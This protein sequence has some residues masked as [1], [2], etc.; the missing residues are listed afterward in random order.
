MNQTMTIFYQGMPCYDILLQQGFHGLYEA[1]AAL[2]ME[3]RRICIVTDSNVNAYYGE[4]LEHNLKEHGCTQILRFVFP[5]GEEHKTLAVIE[6]L[7]EF[8]IQHEFDRSDVLLALGGG[9]VGDM[10]GFAAA[11]YLRGIRFVQVPTTLLSMVD[12]SIG[13]KT[14]V[15]FNGYKN[16][17]GAFYQPSLVFV[18]TNVLATLDERQR[19]SGMGEIIKHGLIKDRSYYEWLVS[20]A[21]E[22]L[23]LDTAALA[24]MIYRSQQ[25]KKAVVENDPKE[26]GERALLNFGHTIGHAIEKALHFKLLH[27]E[28]VALGT[29][30]ASYISFR[31]GFLSR[32]ELMQIESA[33]AAYQLPIRKESLCLSDVLENCR[34]DK[35]KD[36]SVIKFV[37]LK[38]LG[39]AFLTTD[40]SSSE[41]EEAVN[42]LME[43]PVVQ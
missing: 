11:T 15:D 2:S 19:A 41:L 18:N 4:A 7:Y 10:T 21:K 28:C 35:K 5:A 34:H 37:L 9:V 3:K 33:L 22:V 27:G 13:G 29:V 23:A 25:I 32:K 12:S 39:N 17:V 14:G 8:L 38:Q 20:H 6:R 36:G 31:R 43:E 30:A 42:Y 26:Q 1:L 40:V 24:E 16:M